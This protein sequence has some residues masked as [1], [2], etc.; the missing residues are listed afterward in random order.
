MDLFKDIL[1][2][3]TD[4]IIILD[5]LGHIVS[6]NKEAAHLQKSFHKKTA[7]A[8]DRIEA[9]L[10]PEQQAT[11]SEAFLIVKKHRKTYTTF[12]E[13]STQPGTR[14][15]LEIRFVPVL[16]DKGRL[17]GINVVLQDVTSRKIFEAKFKA[18]TSDLANLME[19]ASALIFGIDTRGYI[20]EWNAWCSRVTGYSKNEVFGRK[21]S[22]LLIDQSGCG[23]TEDWSSGVL[24]DSLK[25]SYEF[26][27][28]GKGGN[29]IVIR[30]SMT[31][32]ANT[33][34]QL[35]GT[36]CVGQDIT[37]LTEYRRR[38]QTAAKR[39]IPDES[40]PGKSSLFTVA[41]PI[42]KHSDR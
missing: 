13:F 42:S 22:E 25:A 17:R 29:E 32:R 4:S 31:P 41:I 3:L 34:G 8:G 14:I 40:Q 35:I 24:R 33:H 15:S 36:T 6:Y 37:E 23:K 19:N 16:T 39:I 9:F 20:V 26:R 30:A 18:V 21:L 10:P 2:C 28:K 27:V 1:D 38:E 5:P 12:A 11:L 7:Q